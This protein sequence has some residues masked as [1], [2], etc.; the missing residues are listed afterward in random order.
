[1]NDQDKE[2]LKQYYDEHY[3]KDCGIDFEYLR[4]DELLWIRKTIGF[5]FFRLHKAA[6]S[7]Q[8]SINTYFKFLNKQTP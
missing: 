7:L 5:Y 1:M 6:E 8:Q 4:D 3:K 2:L